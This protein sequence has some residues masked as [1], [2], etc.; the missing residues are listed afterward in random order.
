MTTCNLCRKRGTKVCSST[1]KRK[2]IQLWDQR[3]FKEH[4]H[5]NCAPVMGRDNKTALNAE[6]KPICRSGKVK[7]L[8]KGKYIVWF[9]VI[10]ILSHFSLLDFLPWFLFYHM[11]PKHLPSYVLGPLL[12]PY[13]LWFI[14]LLPFFN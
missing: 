14:F 3:R 6:K 5:V 1:E 13:T 2:S 7:Y 4:R 11:I 8:F 12:T 9:S 10:Y